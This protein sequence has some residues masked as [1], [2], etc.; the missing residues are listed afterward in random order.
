MRTLHIDILD[1]MVICLSSRY[2]TVSILQDL[3]GVGPRIYHMIGMSQI[4]TPTV[5]QNQIRLYQK[6][7][8]LPIKALLSGLMSIPPLPPRGAHG[9]HDALFNGVS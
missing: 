5:H 9:S 6:D 7:P 8:V 3:R 2:S 1:E 4:Y